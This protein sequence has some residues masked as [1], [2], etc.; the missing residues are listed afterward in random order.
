MGWG[1]HAQYPLIGT[2]I[3]ELT[4]FQVDV[5]EYVVHNG[6]IT[7]ETIRID[8]SNYQN[9]ILIP[10]KEYVLDHLISDTDFNWL[11]FGGYWGHRF[12]EPTAYVPFEG[13][14]GNIAPLSPYGGQ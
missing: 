11:V 5:E 12:T 7:D 2:W 10:P 6:S 14:V 4:I 8:F 3:R 9:I 1:S 13:Y